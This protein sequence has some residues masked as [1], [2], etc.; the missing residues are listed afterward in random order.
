LMSRKAVDSKIDSAK[1]AAPKQGVKGRAVVHL[2]FTT[3]YTQ[4]PTAS[5][6]QPTSPNGTT[7]PSTT[8]SG[9]TA[10]TTTPMATQQQAFV[11]EGKGTFGFSLSRDGNGG[12]FSEL[13]L[14]FRSSLQDLLS[15]N[16]VI[17][18]GGLTYLNLSANNPNNVTGL[19]EATAH[20]RLGQ[21]GHDTTATTGGT[22]GN[23]SNLLVIEGGY[24]NNSG[25]QQ[26]IA[27]SPQTN[28][29]DRLV[30]RFYLTPELPGTNHTT[31]TLGMEYS[32]G[33]NGGPKIVQVFVG[34]NVNP[35]KLFS[36]Q[37]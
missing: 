15:P 27:G 26:L 24:Q 13:G 14:G 1:N 5:K 20:Y 19:Y 36:K 11:A 6:V 9:T 23:V 25:L 21:H 2:S 3:G 31:I 37:Q 12:F 16:Q 7:P 34:T 29:R 17:Q 8:S 22:F 4:V 30:G 32:R 10:A 33:I 35:A 28:T 18:S